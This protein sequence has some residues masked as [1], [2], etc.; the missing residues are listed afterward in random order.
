M[1]RRSPTLLLTCAIFVHVQRIHQNNLATQR[2]EHACTPPFFIVKLYPTDA[3]SQLLLL[4]VSPVNF[5]QN[6]SG[7][8]KI[9]GGGGASAWSHVISQI[10]FAS[11]T[12][13]FQMQL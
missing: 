5:F 4:A 12:G 3:G 11:R 13:P 1:Q 9:T 8:V 10:D 6:G 7:V 2:A